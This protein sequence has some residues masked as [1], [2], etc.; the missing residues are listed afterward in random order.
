MLVA[1]PYSARDDVRTLNQVR[2]QPGKRDNLLQAAK[3][4]ERDPGC[5]HYIGSTSDEPEA[6][7]VSEV[8]TDEATHDASLRPR[9]SRALIQEAWPLI[10]DMSGQ[11]RL[12]VHAARACLA[13]VAPAT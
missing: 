7:W 4:L 9:I 12:N 2:A 6:V 5:I 13:E 11:T 10:A 1:P 3:L 8:W